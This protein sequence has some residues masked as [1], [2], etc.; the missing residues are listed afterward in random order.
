IL[1]LDYDRSHGEWH[2]NY[3]GN[4]HN[5]EG[6]AFLKQLNFAI[7]Q[8]YSGV[9]MIA[10]ESS[11]WAQMTTPVENGGMGFD[12]K[13]NMGWMNDSLRY[14]EM[15][16]IYRRYHHNLI[17]FAM[18]YNYSENFILPIS[19]D[20]VVHGK[21]ALVDKM[22]GDLWNKYA[23]LRLFM[24]FMLTH[25]GKKLLFMGSEFAQFVE[26]RESEQLQWQIIDEYLIH[27]QIKNCIKELNFI[28]QQHSPLW[29]ADHLLQGFRWIDA[30]NSQQSIVS[31]VRYNQD[32]SEFLVIICNF[33]NVV[34]YDYQIGVPEAGEYIELFNSDDLAYGGSG[35][36]MSTTI[37]SIEQP[38]K[39]YTNSV[40]IKIPPMAA[41]ILQRISITQ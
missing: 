30:D 32:M 26:W 28:Y 14:I 17:N 25:P 35:Q 13:W 40:R 16:P 7:K 21:K 10:E 24:T 23:G 33:T 18:V 39:D 41:I 8:H 2:H 12:F 20:E 1:Y 37:S 29:E 5:L 9:L 36:I 4:N 15:D 11:A 34:Y 22:A 27:K 3:F 6:I 31:F 19:H 38:F